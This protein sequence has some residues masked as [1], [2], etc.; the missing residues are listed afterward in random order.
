MISETDTI[1]VGGANYRTFRQ[2]FADPIS[3]DFRWDDVVRLLRALKVNV[4]H[5][6]ETVTLERP[7]PAC[8]EGEPLKTTMPLRRSQQKIHQ[9]QARTIKIY[10][11]MLTFTPMRIKP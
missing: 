6:A 7:D 10:L 2:I 9:G 5:G 8:P 1:S 11:T 3:L 4:R